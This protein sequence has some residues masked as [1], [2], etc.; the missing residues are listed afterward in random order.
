MSDSETP[1]T[2]AQQAPPVST[3]SNSHPLSWWCYLTILSSVIPFFFCLQ[4]F[5][6]SGSFLMSWLFTSGGQ[7]I[8]ASASASVLPVNIQGR[9]PLGLTAWSPF[10]P[11]DSQES[12]PAP[13]FKSIN[14][15][16]SAFFMVQ[17]LQLYMIIR[18]TVALTICTFFSQVISLF[19]N[20]LSRFV[21]IFLPRSKRLLISWLQS[22]STVILKPWKIKYH[23]FHFF[24]FHFPWSDGTG[25]HDHSILNVEFE[26]SFF[27][28]LFHPHQET[29]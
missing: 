15:S 17:L 21:I 5:P 16:C 19:S 26:V 1:W 10:S 11:R 18:K 29:L 9:F 14:S 4:S 7:S 8:G 23:C 2:A 6:G 12:S 24:L 20:M 27:T 3:I 22:Q 28:L 25:G 13:Q